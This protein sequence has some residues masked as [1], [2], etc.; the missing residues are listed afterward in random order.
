MRQAS[1]NDLSTPYFLT[2]KKYSTQVD[3]LQ[4]PV[5]SLFTFDF[6][7]VDIH[8]Y[9]CSVDDH[10][11]LREVFKEPSN[12]FFDFHLLVKCL[13]VLIYQ[14]TRGLD[15]SFRIYRIKQSHWQPLLL[16]IRHNPMHWAPD[17]PIAHY[18]CTKKKTQFNNCSLS[19]CKKNT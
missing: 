7:Y 8:L 4:F 15:F 1:H 10:L 14:F 5:K 13:M 18:L 12:I 17:D 19:V 11:S 16:C 3:I 6:Y 2:K 9:P